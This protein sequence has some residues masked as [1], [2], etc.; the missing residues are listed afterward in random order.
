MNCLKCDE[1]LG[2]QRNAVACDSCDRKMHRACSGLTASEIKVMD[3]RNNRQLKFFCQD[4]LEGLAAVPKLLKQLSVLQTQFKEFKAKLDLLEDPTTETPVRTTK[5]Q[6][7]NESVIKE[8]SERQQRASNVM[9]F[10]LEKSNDDKQKISKLFDEIGASSVQI[11]QVS[12]VGKPNKNGHQAL[13]VVL[14][15]CEDV[16]RVLKCKSKLDRSRAIFINADLTSDQREYLNSI[17]TQLRDRIAGGETD[18]TISYIHGVPHIIKTD[19][20]H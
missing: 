6:P 5:L 4:C 19:D 11:K 13:K 3:L 14:N 10:N 12:R 17:K 1:I 15:T 7:M 16:K 8:I 2:D 20:S 9:I 18:L